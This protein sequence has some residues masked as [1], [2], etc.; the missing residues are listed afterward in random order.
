VQRTLQRLARAQQGR[1]TGTTKHR[2][3]PLLSTGGAWRAIAD[4]AG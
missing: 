2:R 3:Q 1:M 4:A